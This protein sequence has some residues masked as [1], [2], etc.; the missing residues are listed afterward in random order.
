MIVLLIGGGVNKD[1]P[2]APAQQPAAAVRSQPATPSADE[3]KALDALAGVY[4]KDQ[5]DSTTLTNGNFE[6][7]VSSDLVGTPDAETWAAKISE[8]K[9]AC[10]SVAQ[11]IQVQNVAVRVSA[12]DGTILLNIL[13]GEITYDK[14]SEDIE[15]AKQEEEQRKQEETKQEPQEQT[16]VLNTNTKKFHDPSCSSVDKISEK[17]KQFVTATRSDVIGMG[18]RACSNCNGG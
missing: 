1:R 11:A 17:N 2:E 12:P 14:V 6:A 4:P 10:A 18:Y 15:E 3:E 13:N 8:A 5:I 9:A 16:Y 7:R